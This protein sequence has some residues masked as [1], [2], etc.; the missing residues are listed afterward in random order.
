[1]NFTP[2]KD[3]IAFLKQR[4]R[5]PDTDLSHDDTQNTNTASSPSANEKSSGA[6]CLIFF[7]AVV[8]ILYLMGK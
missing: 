6:G 8:V 7:I 4:D 2:D 5:I 3:Q 1:M